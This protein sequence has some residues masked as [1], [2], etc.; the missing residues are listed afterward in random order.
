MT[1]WEIFVLPAHELPNADREAPHLQLVADTDDAEVLRLIEEAASNHG[2]QLERVA[3]VPGAPSLPA[4]LRQS[5]E[6]IVGYWREYQAPNPEWPADL[7]FA[8][9]SELL[10]LLGDE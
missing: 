3:S 6:L 1:A 4:H 2:V 7:P 5:C 9:A 10:L 8:L